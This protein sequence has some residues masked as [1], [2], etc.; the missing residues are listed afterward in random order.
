[1][2][3]DSEHLGGTTTVNTATVYGYITGVGVSGIPSFCGRRKNF[4]T[5][6]VLAMAL[7]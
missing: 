1:M 6:T 4:F 3:D 7:E 5:D 2:S